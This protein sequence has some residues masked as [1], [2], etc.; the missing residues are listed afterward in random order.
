VAHKAGTPHREG[1]WDPGV[2]CHEK[3]MTQCEVQKYLNCGG[4]HRVQIPGLQ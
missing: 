4:G 3:Q 2:R 1:G